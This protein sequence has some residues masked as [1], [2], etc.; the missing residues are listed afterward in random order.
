MKTWVILLLGISLVFAPIFAQ[1]S[2][3]RQ[4]VNGLIPTTPTDAA[5]QTVWL[6]GITLT[7]EGATDANC[8]ILEKSTGRSIYGSAAKPGLVQGGS[9]QVRS[10]P[11]RRAPGGITWSCDVATVNGWIGYRTSPTP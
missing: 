2:L 4:D 9:E 8:I 6:I 10:Y 7:N 1:P 11:Q 3:V 5:T